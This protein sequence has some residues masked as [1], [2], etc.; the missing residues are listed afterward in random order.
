MLYMSHLHGIVALLSEHWD[1]GGGIH[2]QSKVSDQH[3]FVEHRGNCTSKEIIIIMQK[4]IFNLIYWCRRTPEKVGITLGWVL[5]VGCLWYE[6]SEQHLTYHRYSRQWSQGTVG[7]KG[8]V[9]G[10][11]TSMA[12]IPGL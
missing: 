6:Y 12:N 1:W 8:W 9:Q 11:T 4:Q 3:G 10:E 2:R 7:S 5:Q